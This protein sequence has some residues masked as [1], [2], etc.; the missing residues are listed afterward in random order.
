MCG[1]RRNSGFALLML[2]VV[3]LG[4]TT[5]AFSNILSNSVRQKADKKQDKNREALI[6]A[7]EALL[8]F[9]VDFLRTNSLDNCTVFGC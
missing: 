5:L 4:M 8:A 9:S 7:K 2:L 3:L 6:E 1:K